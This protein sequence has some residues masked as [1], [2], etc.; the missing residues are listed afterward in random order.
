MRVYKIIPISY[1]FAI[2]RLPRAENS[3]LAL[4]HTYE[5]NR[6]IVVHIN[7]NSKMTLYMNA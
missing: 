5:H 4:P 6:V 2:L 7:R 1:C 3:P